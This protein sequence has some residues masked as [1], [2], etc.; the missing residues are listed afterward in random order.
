MLSPSSTAVRESSASV[1]LGIER[2]ALKEARGRKL[3]RIA[4]DDD[5]SAARERADRVFRLELGCL[6][7]HDEIELQL[8]GREILGDGQRP[9]HEARFER[10][11]RIC[12]AL[13]QLADGN[14]ALL[15]VDFV[16]DQRHLRPGTH[17]T[18]LVS[19]GTGR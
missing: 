2:H 19:I 15:F 6:I 16:R 4:D 12:G 11:Q 10:H 14:V 17:R 13:D 3:F 1:V 5:L 8:A 18:A 9:H 7:H